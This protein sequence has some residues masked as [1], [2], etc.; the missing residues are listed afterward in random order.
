[1]GEGVIVT[2]P[3]MDLLLVLEGGN[4]E[5]EFSKISAKF[6]RSQPHKTIPKSAPIR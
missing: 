3:A 4:L 2:A 5:F 1:M 6:E